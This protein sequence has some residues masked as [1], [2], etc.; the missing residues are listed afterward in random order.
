VHTEIHKGEVRS[1]GIRF[2]QGLIARPEFGPF[3]LLVL[4]IIVFT[5]RSPA[6]ISPGNISNLLAFTP[7]L[8]MI[9]LGMTLLMVSGEFDLSV[10]SVFGFAPIVMWTCYN[11]HLTSL[12]IGFLIAIL[13]SAV[14]GFVNGWFVTKLKIPSFLVTLG[15]LLVVRGTALY[16]TDGFPQRTWTADSLLMRVIVGE[17]RLADLRIY[18]SLLWFIF[19]ALVLGYVLVG[20]KAG[21]WILAS[22]GNPE[23]ARARGVRVTRT[24][25]ILFILTALI[26]AYAGITSSIR[27]SAA[28]PNSGTGY[29]LE[30]IA[31][32]VIGGTALSG[33]RGT[34]VGTVLGVL[35]LRMMRNGIVLIGVPGLAYNIFIGGII[36][37]MMALH[38]WLER[39]HRRGT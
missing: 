2:L 27:V 1:N 18:T 8:G 19:F 39:R 32:V 9:S 20:S 21:N 11:T 14:I 4:E 35:I 33:G 38:S 5:A 10:G 23:A 30:V 29:E 26:S 22:G 12:E 3:V 24:K 15:M 16:I 31:M 6:F 34:I 17:F 28:N 36:L 37:G 7:E 25:M 13:I